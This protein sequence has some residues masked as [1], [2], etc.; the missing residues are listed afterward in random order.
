MIA[1]SY[2]IKSDSVTFET[3]GSYH[4][5]NLS[6]YLFP[7][8]IVNLH[9]KRLYAVYGHQSDTLYFDK[10]IDRPI[11]RWT[12]FLDIVAQKMNGNLHFKSLTFKEGSNWK[13]SD[14]FEKRDKLIEARVRKGRLDFYLNFESRLFNLKSYAK[15][16][17]CYVAPLPKPIPIKDQILFL[18]LDQSC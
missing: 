5:E 13:W 6:N 1:M 17:M 15:S 11:C 18:P 12:H 2:D 14:F 8:K 16:P 10:E 7:D 4:L 3:F 9:R